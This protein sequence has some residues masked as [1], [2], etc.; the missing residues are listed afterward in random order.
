MTYGGTVPTLTWHA[1]FPNNGDS[2]S[3]L[4]TQPTCVAA[5]TT[6]HVAGS[7]YVGAITCSGAV[8]SNYTIGYAA[9]NLS[10]TPASLTITADDQT[11]TYGGTVP[12]LT[13]KAN[14]AN[15]DSAASL[16][17]QP[18]CT[19]THTT[20]HV[21]GS[22]YV[23]AITCSGA[24]DTDYNISY[25]AG[26]LT[27]TPAN[28]TITADNKSVQYSDL[29][30]PLT[31]S[32]NGFVNGDGSGV[33]GGTLACSTTAS[34]AANG[35]VLSPAGPYTITCSGLSDTDYTVK[36]MSG[37]LT[38][39][40]EGTVVKPAQNNPSAIQVTKP[41][42][43]APA[44]TFSARI[45]EVADPGETAFGDITNAKPITFSLNPIGPGS[46]YSCSTSSPTQVVPATSTTPGFEVVSCTI[47]AGTPV[48][49]YDVHVSVGGNFYQGAADRVVTVFDPSQAGVQSGGGTLINPKDGNTVSF[50]FTASYN[51]GGGTVGKMFYVETD[52]TGTQVVSLKGNVMSTLAIT[53]TNGTYPETATITGKATLNG[54]GNYSYI[55]Q[56]LDALGGVQPD[57]DQF[58]MQVTDPTKAP[59]TSLS[60]GLQPLQTGNI[61]VQ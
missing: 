52:N 39:T 17:I 61:L 13:W 31:V 55:L 54:V 44:M 1:N 57:A 3:S 19:A 6:D 56:G 41:G 14:F 48:N 18:T 24:A 9:G 25:A 53:R 30:P 51:K 12:T 42:G 32:Y 47:P 8:D 59:V 40:T 58:G 28:L 36:F 50:G 11:M 22:P 46:S 15:G 26:D 49:V 16:T 37:T 34:V 45:T 2:A 23:G 27:I 7:P 10:I 21:A 38:V 43:S 4:S 29:L 35:Q 33:L 60:F 5:H 20:D